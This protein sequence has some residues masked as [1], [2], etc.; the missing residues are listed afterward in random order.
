[1]PATIDIEQVYV[2]SYF[3]DVSTIKWFEVP[4]NNGFFTVEFR[5]LSGRELAQEIRLTN[6][7]NTNAIKFKREYP[8]SSDPN[9]K[10]D[11]ITVFH[12]PDV[13][14]DIYAIQNIA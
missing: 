5:I 3:G 6:P 11:T 8:A 2:S 12:N 7:N 9:P 4:P 1:M 10:I 13:M 14:S